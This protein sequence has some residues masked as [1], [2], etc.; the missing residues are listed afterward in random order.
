VYDV[1]GNILGQLENSG[2]VEGIG[3]A[4]VVGLGLQG[5]LVLSVHIGQ[6]VELLL[7]G[8]TSGEEGDS[9]KNNE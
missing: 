3:T 2:A 5:G 1:I 8:K 6:E 9:Q 4:L 7:F